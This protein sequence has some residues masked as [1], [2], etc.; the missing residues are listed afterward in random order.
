MNKLKLYKTSHDGKIFHN[1]FGRNDM[2]SVGL[3]LI[4]IKSLLYDD[5]LVVSLIKSLKFKSICAA[6]ENIFNVFP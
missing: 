4:L 2:K 5:A 6:Y 3:A 1:N